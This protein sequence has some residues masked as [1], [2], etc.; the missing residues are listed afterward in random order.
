VTFY[1]APRCHPQDMP[2]ILHSMLLCVS[3]VGAMS[4]KNW[5]N[6]SSPRIETCSNLPGLLPGDKVITQ[7]PNPTGASN[8]GQGV[9]GTVRCLDTTDRDDESLVVCFNSWTGG[10][11]GTTQSCNTCIVP[12]C[13]DTSNWWVHC[14]EVAFYSST[15]EK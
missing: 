8:L 1:V 5:N 9:V 13:G 14:N 6:Y 7:V 2:S 12:T 11:D 15:V 4:S 3:L 10:H